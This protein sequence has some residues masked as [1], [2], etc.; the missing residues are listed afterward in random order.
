MSKNIGVVTRDI[1]SP[2]AIQIRIAGPSRRGINK[3]QNSD[4]SDKASAIAAKL[5][6]SCLPA[7]IATKRKPIARLRPKFRPSRLLA[8]LDVALV[9]TETRFNRV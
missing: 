7:N 8:R 6:R 2:R 4:I 9:T 3:P 5:R 1:A